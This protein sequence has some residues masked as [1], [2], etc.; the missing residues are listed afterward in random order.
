MTDRRTFLGGFA[1]SGLGVIA[2]CLSGD[3]AQPTGESSATER[4]AGATADGAGTPTSAAETPPDGTESCPM[5]ASPTGTTETN[6]TGT[7]D[8]PPATGTSTGGSTID[9]AVGPEGRLRFDPETVEIRVGDA[10]RWTFDSAG[11]NVTSLPGASEK[12]RNPEGAEPFASYE[13]D[14]HYSINEVGS[15]FEHVFTVPG[16]YVYVCEPHEDQGMVGTVVVDG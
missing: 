3:G 11:H 4:P 12:V 8:C 2:G 16:E 6:G 9:V 1:A 7:P 14:R 5:D 15:T 13:G 10:V